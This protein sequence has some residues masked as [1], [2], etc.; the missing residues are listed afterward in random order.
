MF[1]SSR[2]T[3]LVTV[4][5]FNMYIFKTLTLLELYSWSS[6]RIPPRIDSHTTLFPPELLSY[7]SCSGTEETFIFAK[8]NTS[9]STPSSLIFPELKI[10]KS[11]LMANK[12]YKEKENFPWARAPNI[13]AT[14]RALARFLRLS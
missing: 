11:I 5:E 14:Q 1:P 12:S 13:N 3:G 7:E 8:E 9:L 2:R 6:P 10:L 4:Q